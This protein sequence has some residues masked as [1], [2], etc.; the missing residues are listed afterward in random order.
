M[1]VEHAAQFGCPC[2]VVEE[3]DRMTDV[4]ERCW[5]VG[6]T[7]TTSGPLENDETL[8]VDFQ[9][10]PA[11]MVGPELFTEA[12]LLREPVRWRRSDV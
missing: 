7:Y 1:R 3:G 2:V 9:D 11:R 12:A 8:V 6:A 4:I 10:W 5:E